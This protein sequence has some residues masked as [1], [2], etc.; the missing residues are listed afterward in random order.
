MKGSINTV[1]LYKD[2][3]YLAGSVRVLL[4][5]SMFKLP[6]HILLTA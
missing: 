2:G 6:T 4:I 5:Y 1:A 3:L